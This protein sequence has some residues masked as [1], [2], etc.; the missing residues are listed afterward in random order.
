[1]ELELAKLTTVSE[2][3]IR[4]CGFGED[5]LTKLY[6][7][8][9]K[10][11]KWKVSCGMICLAITGGLVAYIASSCNQNY[12]AMM[13]TIILGGMVAGLITH[14]NKTEKNFVDREIRKIVDDRLVAL[15]KEVRGQ[16][17]KPHV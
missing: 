10:A 5:K 11:A 15:D 8:V 3:A 9:S 16:E 4:A 6:N 2:A 7:E 12:S 17:L 13:A 14:V 1:M